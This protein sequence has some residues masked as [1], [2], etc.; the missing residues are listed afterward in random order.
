MKLLTDEKSYK[1]I[2]AHKISYKNL[3]GAKPLHIAF[4]KI[5]GF[6]R[7]FNVY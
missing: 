7:V 5:D 4:N 3:T 1:N 2:L 6:I